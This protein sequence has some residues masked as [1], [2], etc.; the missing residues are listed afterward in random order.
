MPIYKEGPNLYRLKVWIRGKPVSRMF[1]GTKA[2]A[3]LAEASFRLEVE[4]AADAPATEAAPTFSTFCVKTYLPLARM[5]LSPSWFRNVRYILATLI[6]HFGEMPLD[7][8]DI[9]EIEGYAAER[10]EDEL[11]PSSVNGELRVLRRILSVAVEREVLEKVPKVAPLTELPKMVEVWSH[12]EL[13]ELFVACAK[14]EFRHILGIVTFL[15]H[16]GCRRGEALAL[17]W[18]NVDLVRGLVKIWPSAVW[19]PK[20][21]RPREVPIAAALRPWLELPRRSE[22]VFPTF[23]GRGKN[24]GRKSW[25][26]RAFS[27]AV[28]AAGLVGTPHKLRHTFAAHFLARVPDLT[29]LAELLGHSDQAV[30]KLY[31]HLLPD[32]LARARGAVEV[33]A[34]A[35]AAEALAMERWRADRRRVKP[36]GGPSGKA[37]PTAAITDEKPNDIAGAGY[38]VRTGDIKLGKLDD[39]SKILKLLKQ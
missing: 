16:T 22:Y 18:E 2:Q 11:E 8:I 14:M 5:R 28:E 23:H 35:A 32:H 1:H 34:P 13:T 12:E 38:R 4:A 17:R 39:R 27:A 3:E 9:G 24:A 21:N 33:V 19:R 26:A 36:S 37:P 25:P 10:L 30:T 7:E 29:L 15:A 6:Q 31:K 20:S